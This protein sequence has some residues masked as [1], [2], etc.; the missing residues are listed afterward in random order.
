MKCRSPA[1]FD[2][3]SSQHQLLESR[4]QVLKLVEPAVL[5]MDRYQ[6]GE[7]ECKLLQRGQSIQIGRGIVVIRLGLGAGIPHRAGQVELFQRGQLADRFHVGRMD[8]GPHQVERLDAKV[9]RGEAGDIP[10]AA[11]VA[12]ENHESAHVQ[13]PDRHLAIR[14][15]SPQSMDRK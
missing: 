5:E 12:F 6:K 13:S 1:A 8:V 3:S 4:P 7:A 14:V 2:Q 9:V 10:D 11:P 15:G